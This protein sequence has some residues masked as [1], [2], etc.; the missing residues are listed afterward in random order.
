[1]PGTRQLC[2]FHA[3]CAQVGV[4]LELWRVMSPDSLVVA[5]QLAALLGTQHEPIRQW[6]TDPKLMRETEVLHRRQEWWGS[7]VAK[8][9]K[10]R[11]FQ[12]GTARDKV[13]RIAQDGPVAS[14]WLTAAP[15]RSLGTSL[16]EIDFRSLCRFWLG[17][18]LLAEAAGTKVHRCPACNEPCDSYGDHFVN[19]RHNGMT[20][21]HNSVRDEWARI[22]LAAHVPYRT[23]VVASALKRPADILLIGWDHGRDVA[24]D[25]TVTNPLSADCYPLTYEGAKRHLSHAERDE[26]TKEGPLCASAGWAFAPCALSP[27]GAMGPSARDLLA[28]VTKRAVSD[29]PLDSQ[30]AR[31]VELRQGLSLSLARDIARQLSLRCSV[32]DAEC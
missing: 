1:M 15:S 7:E 29:L 17:I 2:L 18:P 11:L 16:S 28:A 32:I 27:W 30:S 10:A 20:R 21:R 31:A 24:I 19:C 22:L 4:P 3:Q 23:E 12:R 13:R 8:A 26:V 5:E 6:I 25:F 14:A 9:R